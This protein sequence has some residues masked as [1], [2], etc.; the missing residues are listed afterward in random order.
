VL[1]SHFSEMICS[2]ACPSGPARSSAERP[3]GLA[4]PSTASDVIQLGVRGRRSSKRQEQQAGQRSVR[5]RALE[6]SRALCRASAWWRSW[7][8]AMPAADAGEFA[9]PKDFLISRLLPWP[10][11]SSDTTNDSRGGRDRSKLPNFGTEKD[12]PSCACATRLPYLLAATNIA[13][14]AL[15]FFC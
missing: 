5:V 7:S 2:A 13:S 12:D 14:T 3:H 6:R 4:T 8:S 9:W 11:Q 10:C 15:F 1:R